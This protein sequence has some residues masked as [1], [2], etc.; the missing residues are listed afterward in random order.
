MDSQ[1]SKSPQSPDKPH[2]PLCESNDQSC[3]PPPSPA[4]VRQNESYCVRVQAAYDEFLRPLPA[5]PTNG[6][7]ELYPNRIASF[8]KALPHDL[9]GVVDPS[10][11]QTLLDALQTQEPSDFDVIPMGASPSV[12]LVNPQAA[13]AF[14]LEGA[15]S[16]SLAVLPAPTFVS[17]QQASETVELYNMALMRD[18]S[19]D[20]Y[21][22]SILASNA[23][24]Y[25]NATSDFRGPKINGL[26]TPQ[27]LF[28]GI[29]SGTLTGP[30]VSQFLYQ[31]FA[32]GALS[33]VN[34]SRQ[35]VVDADYLTTFADWLPIQNGEVVA[36]PIFP[37]VRHIICGR[38]LAEV[39][40]ESIPLIKPISLILKTFPKPLPNLTS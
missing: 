29:L 7:D 3:V 28:R 39:I 24:I 22:T 15:D 36:Q 32:Y 20:K 5:R 38:D 13:F 25:L 21:G 17:A 14:D 23:V 34:K 6:D 30:F 11:Y 31:P 18:V 26:V 37:N 33:I 8:S 2:S 9:S 4:I 19:F 40:F 12:L 27:T 1:T 10:A 35:T 16:G